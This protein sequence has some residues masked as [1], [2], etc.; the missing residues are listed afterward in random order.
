MKIN[1]TGRVSKSSR[2]S[3]KS[4]G[5]TEKSSG[6]SN[7]QIDDVVELSTEAL[8]AS[9][10]DDKIEEISAIAAVDNYSSGN[11]PDAYATSQAIIESELGLIKSSNR[12]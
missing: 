5:R 1:K 4:K 6:R 11:M 3:K 7:I 12:G 10:S 2:V 9:S 8:M